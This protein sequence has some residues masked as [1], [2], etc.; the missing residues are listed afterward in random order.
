MPEPVKKKA[1]SKL[2]KKAGEKTIIR[3]KSDGSTV[4]VK[5]PKMPASTAEGIPEDLK[6]THGLTTARYFERV[7]WKAGTILK[8]TDEGIAQL[9]TMYSYGSQQDECAANLGVSVDVLQNE[10]NADADRHA[11]EVGYAYWRQEIRG[12]QRHILREGD[13]KMAIWLGKQYLGQQD[14]M[15]ITATVSDVPDAE[16]LTYDEAMDLLRRVAGKSLKAEQRAA[17][18]KSKKKTKGR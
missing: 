17:L 5:P 18:R 7:R 10:A 4:I 15:D 2:E 8:L 16:D 14:R 1:S 6:G 3:K 13:T 12:V 11:R 9:I